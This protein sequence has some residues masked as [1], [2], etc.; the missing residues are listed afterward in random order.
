[1]AEQ[2]SFIAN[3]D[4]PAIPG[5]RT[6]LKVIAW[7]LGLP[8]AGAA[9]Y[10]AFMNVGFLAG[11]A[12]TPLGQAAGT[13]GGIVAAAGLSMLI[14]AIGICWKDMRPVALMAAGL[15][16]LCLVIALSAMGS[17][18]WVSSQPMRAVEKAAPQFDREP[19]R[20]ATIDRDISDFR[21]RERKYY[22]EPGRFVY[23]DGDTIL[24]KTSQCTSFKY[25]WE[26][27]A[28]E[29]WDDLQAEK[30][31]SE[32]I[33]GGGR[34]SRSDNITVP[35][36]GVIITAQAQ[37][38]GHYM[39]A[40][41]SHLIIVAFASVGLAIVFG[42]AHEL[43]KVPPLPVAA[44]PASGPG[45]KDQM[46]VMKE[47]FDAWRKACVGHQDGSVLAASDVHN[48]YAT[49]CSRVLGVRAGDILAPNTFGEYM[50]TVATTVGKA[51]TMKYGGIVISDT[52]GIWNDIERMRESEG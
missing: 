19:R 7:L 29:R 52:H 38:F 42:C 13:V 34:G 9:A 48:H 36:S 45:P 16:G 37:R 6:A 39:S 4:K 40:W 31:A 17:F 15:F 25:A 30:A 11:G 3:V 27:G 51:S 24:A 18:T 41:W 10:V 8:A 35:G 12:A 14:V 47:G 5:S 50:R 33:D 23:V 20:L 28:C 1:M 44:P 32:K 21:G 49:W 26:R 43:T 46:T 22:V 2:V